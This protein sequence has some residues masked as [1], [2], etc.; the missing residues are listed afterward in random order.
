MPWLARACSGGVAAPGECRLAKGERRLARLVV[1][2][3]PRA[4]AMLI[5]SFA[6]ITWGVLS[7]SWDEEVEGS[8]LGVELVSLI[9]PVKKK[10]RGKLF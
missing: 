7:T 6:G 8:L 5:L 9:R 3:S 10:R 2:L 4:Q 1:R